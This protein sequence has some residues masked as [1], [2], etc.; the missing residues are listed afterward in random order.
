MSS[1]DSKCVNCQKAIP[2]KEF[3]ICALCGK[4]YDIVCAKI[5]SQ[6]YNSFYAGNQERKRKWKCLDCNNEA[7][8]SPSNQMT[9]SC[10]DNVTTRPKRA[11]YIQYDSRNEKTVL[12]SQS[13]SGCLTEDRFRVILSDTIK[14][15]VSSE[16][17]LLKD[18]VN[19]L[20]ESVS[21]YN[22]KYE[23]IKADLDIKT[24]IIKDLKVDNEM[25]KT[26]VTDLSRR[27]NM[28]E[29]N[30]REANVE[31]NGIPEHKTENLVKTMEQ[32][33]KAVNAHNVSVEDVIH[34]TR[35]AKLNRGDERPRTVVAKLRTP[36][37]RDEILAAVT[38]FNKKQSNDKLSSHHLGI[39]GARSPIYVSE[40]LSPVNKAIHAAAR[41]KAKELGYKF[42]WV[43]N[44]RIFIRKDEG[45]EF[46]LVRGME[47]L[48]YLK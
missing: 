11:Q 38:K 39:G 19:E 24:T 43:R 37:H 14:Q 13:H 32:I 3:L 7:S 29:Q 25:L 40:H 1:G 20:R 28:V 46:L 10:S 47:S 12:E 26:T 34:V 9:S 35:V 23:E 41:I 2:N 31:I 8:T 42:T 44:G 6:R 27:L 17:K 16:I 5:S 45:S 22:Q 36:R 48:K 15:L 18:E 30:A 21:F 33:I 4:R